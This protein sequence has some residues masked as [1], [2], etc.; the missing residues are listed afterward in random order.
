MVSKK[1]PANFGRKAIHVAGWEVLLPRLI[2]KCG[3]GLENIYYLVHGPCHLLHCF[4]MNR[5]PYNGFHRKLILAF[6]IG[7]TY[8]G[9]AYAF[10]D[11]GEVPEIGSVRK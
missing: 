11:P 4:F 9:V 6:D 3:G 7:T 10:L 2:G 1:P 5:A 8:S